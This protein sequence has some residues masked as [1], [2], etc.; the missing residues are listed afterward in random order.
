MLRKI[1]TRLKLAFTTLLVAL[2]VTNAWAQDLRLEI[3]APRVVSTGEMFRLAFVANAKVDNFTPPSFDG[4]TVTAGP[5][6]A[7]QTSVNFINGKVTQ[8][9]SSTFT[10]TLYAEKEGKFTIGP[11]K[12]KNGNEEAQTQPFTIECVKGQPAQAQQAQGQQS[13]GAATS[14][15]DLY[16]ALT[17]NKREVY[18]GE[19]LVATLKLYN[20]SA[21]IAD[22]GNLK[23]PSF[24]GFWNQNIEVPSQISFQRENVNG[25]V[26]ETGL[27]GKQLLFPQQAG[28]LSIG[29]SEVDV[30]VQIRTRSRDMFEDF[31][32]GGYQNVRK[33]LQS[34][35]VK[36]KVKDLPAGAPVSFSGA[37]GSFKMEASLSKK[38]LTANDATSLTIRIS[39]N[40]N[41]KL[42]N[43]PK[44][45]FPVDFE[46]YDT[47]A[48]E[49]IKN[50][51]AGSSGYRQFEI[52][53]IPRSAGEFMIPA[54]EFSYFN[55]STGKYVT[56]HTPEQTISVEKDSR[57][58][59]SYSSSEGRRE[60][61]K[62]LGQDI[63]FIKTGDNALPT[64]PK[65]FL[66]SAMFYLLYITA[67]IL[68]STIYILS[69][70]RIK[71]NKNI[72]L[73]KNKKANK[74]AR[75][76]LKASAQLLK[77]GNAQGF[78]N[79]LLRAM[80]GYLSDKLSIPVAE[81]SRENAQQAFTDRSIEEAYIT[82]FLSVIDECEFARYAPGSGRQEME[83]V[84]ADAVGVISKLEQRIK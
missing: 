36:I 68:F 44:V 75:K 54:I 63:R 27:L 69:K 45:D 26:F 9:V 11:A 56:L 22:L 24:E 72:V 67:I 58:Q 10:Y 61:I 50:S 47:K 77:M 1:T 81:L 49:S 5:I 7:S 43:A 42:I 84:Y 62:V 65:F 76:R 82:T 28:E 55:P 2:C 41:L 74:V 66:G 20:R 37:V 48:T 64:E 6:Q 33:H 4:F 25:T 34:K 46:V 59:Q 73:V 18:R 29:S 53:L 80:W 19:H 32:G 78:Y 39:G 30:V 35:S 12:V 40:G 3:Q 79:E 21:A 8:S 60:G 16:L 38:Q 15:D 70:K 71:E 57:V 31:F 23:N 83:Q 17:V 51:D 13:S 52:P 14:S